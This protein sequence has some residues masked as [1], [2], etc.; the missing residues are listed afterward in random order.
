MLACDFFVT[1]TA[2]FRTLYVF[3]V[4][5]VGTRRRRSESRAEP[6]AMPP[7]DDVRLHDDQGG[8]P[9]LPDSGQYDPKQSVARLEARALVL[10]FI[11]VSCCRSATFSR[12]NSRC[13]RDADASAGPITMSSSCIHRS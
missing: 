10:R 7:H 5:D 1:I 11:A 8:V 3:V 9:V 2:S 12:T 4:L 13:L 6:V